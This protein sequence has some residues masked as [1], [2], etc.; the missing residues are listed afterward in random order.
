MT[1]QTAMKENK[2]ISMILGAI[3][4]GLL[5]WGIWVTD[6]AYDVKYGKKLIESRQEIVSLKQDAII[7]LI[8]G[9]IFELQATDVILKEELKQQRDMIHD[10]HQKVLKILLDIQRNVRE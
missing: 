7:K 6:A 5:A 9:D 1:I 2:L 8:S 10:N 4:T 3:A